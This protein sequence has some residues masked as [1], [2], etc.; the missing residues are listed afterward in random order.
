MIILSVSVTIVFRRYHHRT[1]DPLQRHVQTKDHRSTGRGCQRVSQATQCHHPVRSAA[2][3]CHSTVSTVGYHAGE[4]ASV[5]STLWCSIVRFTNL[6]STSASSRRRGRYCKAQQTRAA[7]YHCLSFFQ[8]PPQNF[9]PSGAD[10]AGFASGNSG[11]EAAGGRSSS[12]SFASSSYGAQQGGAGLANFESAQGNLGGNYSSIYQSGSSLSRDGNGVTPGYEV[13]G[14]SA[15]NRFDGSQSI[16]NS[17]DI[18]NDGSIDPNE[19]R[20]FLGSQLQ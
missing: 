16:F 20:Q 6:D 17:A 10:A 11:G 12:S 15:G 13:Y 8:S 9:V 1:L 14:T 4:S 2:G 7:S 19:F 3:S 18:N 5:C